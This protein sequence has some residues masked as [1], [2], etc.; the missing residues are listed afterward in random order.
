M[1][2]VSDRFLELYSL[3]IPKINHTALDSFEY[4]S[5]GNKTS[6]Q[7]QA[8]QWMADEDTGN[9]PFETSFVSI[10]TERYALMVLYFGHVHSIPALEECGFKSSQ[11]VCRCDGPN[12]F[13]IWLS[14][15]CRV[16]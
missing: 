12:V 11:S 16:K 15:N 13:R 9:F 5:G 4:F 14:K 1:I 8:I 6:A 3:L 2:D 10:L 7:F